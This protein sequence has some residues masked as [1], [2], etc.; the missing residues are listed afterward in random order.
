M[1]LHQVT[2]HLNLTSGRKGSWDPRGS[3]GFGQPDPKGQ[4]EAEVQ[5]PRRTAPCPPF[6]S[7][8]AI[9]PLLSPATG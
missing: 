7:L 9:S 2:L 3:D 6:D 5:K 1:K 4:A 8:T